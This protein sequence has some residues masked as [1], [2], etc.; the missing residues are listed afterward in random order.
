MLASAGLSIIVGMVVV[1]RRFPA[2]AIAALQ[3]RPSAGR[4]LPRG[5]FTARAPLMLTLGFCL[6]RTALSQYPDH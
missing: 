1:R 4:E 3:W 5:W 2:L 6:L